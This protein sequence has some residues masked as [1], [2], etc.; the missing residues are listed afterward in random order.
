MECKTITSLRPISLSNMLHKTFNLIS[1]VKGISLLWK[2][3]FFSEV[4]MILSYQENKFNEANVIS[5]YQE[6]K[7]R[8]SGL[9]S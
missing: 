9:K 6:T 2:H 4:N 7:F 5:V 3:I 8:S 1:Y